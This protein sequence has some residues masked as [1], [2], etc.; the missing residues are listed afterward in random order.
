AEKINSPWPSQQGHR[1]EDSCQVGGVGGRILMTTLPD[2]C[3]AEFN[4]LPSAGLSPYSGST[5][6]SS[7]AVIVILFP[8]SVRFCQGTAFPAAE[9]VVAPSRKKS[10][11]RSITPH[12]LA[13]P[14]KLD[15]LEAAS[16]GRF[17]S[18]RARPCP[19]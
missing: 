17:R 10:H 9:G 1:S 3:P 8:A 16:P 4:N 15:H 18:S 5:S 6:R 7:F 13:A 14:R 2:W 11:G 19:N 12:E